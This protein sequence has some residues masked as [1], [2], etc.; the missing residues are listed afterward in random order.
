MFIIILCFGVLVGFR[1]SDNA[2][3]FDI[4]ELYDY[5][6]E[7]NTVEMDVCSL[8]T[9][10]SYESYRAITA[11]D[12]AQYKFIRNYMHVDEETGLLVDNDGFIGVALGSYYSN[13]IGTRFYFTMNT[14]VV[15][16]FVMID[17]KA[18]AETDSMHCY[19]TYDGSM[20]ELVIDPLIA[21]N[22][23]NRN[24]YSI[25][26]AG[27]FNNFAPFNGYVVKVEKVL[28]ERN[29]DYVTFTEQDSND[30][31]IDNIYYYAS[32]Y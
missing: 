6:K 16:P 7:Y 19:H 3:T 32:G 9:T 13:V 2:K 18:D 22:Y 21:K 23:F 10:K 8:S 1:S 20:I 12:S 26:V 28:D 4:N 24:G 14:G 5:Q 30:L 29:E 15:I 25:T 17:Q 31:N 11:V 27:N